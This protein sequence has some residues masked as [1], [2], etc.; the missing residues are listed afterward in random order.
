M[1]WYKKSQIVPPSSNLP[2][3]SND[4]PSQELTSQEEM[5]KKRLDTR[6]KWELRKKRWDDLKAKGRYWPPR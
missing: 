4:Q 2:E 5:A 6:K 3:K 1:N